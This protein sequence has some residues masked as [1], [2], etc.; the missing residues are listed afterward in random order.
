MIIWVIQTQRVAELMNKNTAD[1][2]NGPPVRAKTQRTPIRVERLI[3]VKEN[4]S[5]D[6][7]AAP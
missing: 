5:L 4:V 2:A 7:I 1:I 6:N 3:F